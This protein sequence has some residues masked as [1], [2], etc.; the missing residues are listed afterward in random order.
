MKRF[1][2]S[3]SCLA[4]TLGLLVCCEKENVVQ[5]RYLLSSEITVLNAR[6]VSKEYWFEIEIAV[7][8]A[9]RLDGYGLGKPD[10]SVTLT[11]VGATEQM[12]M[13]TI[14]TFRMTV[15]TPCTFITYGSLRE[16]NSPGYAMI[17]SSKA[18]LPTLLPILGMDEDSL[19]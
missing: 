12:E 9:K 4:V 16:R 7:E 15:F 2:S 8:A 10:G 5:D 13:P 3:L 11:L 14:S 19:E 1:L 18:A 6:K 17:K